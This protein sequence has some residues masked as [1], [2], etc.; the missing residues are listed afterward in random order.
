M[1]PRLHRLDDSRVVQG[2]LQRE[3][4][5]KSA[6]MLRNFQGS[7]EHHCIVNSKQES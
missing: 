1:R 5:P 7:L 6:M 4:T 2:Y 3:L